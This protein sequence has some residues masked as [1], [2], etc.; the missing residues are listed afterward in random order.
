MKSENPDAPDQVMDYDLLLERLG[1]DT[2]LVRELAAL[3][4]VEYPKQLADLESAVAARDLKR[5][6]QA[7][8]KIKGTARNFAATNAAD[9]AQAL[10]Q[11]KELGDG[12]EI[13]ETAG[14]LALE[15]RRLQTALE[16]VLARE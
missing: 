12:T 3:Y 4:I 13:S 5:V 8:H 6:Q 2:E 7:A 10:E 1:G 11:T 9:T 16:E 15:L 14:R